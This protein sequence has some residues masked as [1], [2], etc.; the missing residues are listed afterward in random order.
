MEVDVALDTAHVGI[1]RTAPLPAARTPL[2]GRRHDVDAVRRLLGRDDVPLVTLTGPG[3]VGKTRLA[4]QV[5][6]ELGRR[7]GTGFA[8]SS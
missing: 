1:G 4:I 8:S 7:S 6:V 5:A 3:G 2:V